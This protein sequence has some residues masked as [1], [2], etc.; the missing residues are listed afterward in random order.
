MKWFYGLQSSRRLVLASLSDFKPNSCREVAEVTGLS[1][2]SA[3][4][5][6]S[7]IG[8]GLVLR[9]E[10]PYNGL[11]TTGFADQSEDSPLKILRLTRARG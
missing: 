1:L 2:N 10:K 4:C 11:T 9:N 8:G 6:L 3:Y 5:C 7:I